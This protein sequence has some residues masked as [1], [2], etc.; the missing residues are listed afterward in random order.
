MVGVGFDV[1]G[2]GD[3]GPFMT[4]QRG[5]QIAAPRLTLGVQHVVALTVCGVAGQFVETGGAP[6]VGVDA[7]VVL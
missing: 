1:I 3:N 4:L 5:M 7:P 6:H 2:G